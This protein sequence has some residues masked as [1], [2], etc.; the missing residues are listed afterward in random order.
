MIPMECIWRMVLPFVFVLSK[1]R[2]PTSLVFFRLNAV[3]TA[4]ALSSKGLPV[5]ISDCVVES[6]ISYYDTIYCP[7]AACRVQGKSY[8]ECQCES[9]TDFC[10]AYQNKSKYES[11]P[12]TLLYFELIESQEAN[13]VLIVAGHLA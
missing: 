13:L 6:Y 1:N 4:K 8:E 2:S 9:Y 11:D 7:F 5:S 12:K 10:G 3:C